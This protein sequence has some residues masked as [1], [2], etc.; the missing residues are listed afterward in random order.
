MITINL[1]S[2]EEKKDI[3][4]ERSNISLVGSF[5]ILGFVLIMLTF[6][7]YT[8]SDVQKGT[9]NAV[10]SETKN[11]EKFLNQEGNAQIE[12]KIKQINNYLSTI[13]AIEEDRTDFAKTLTEIANQTITGIR[14]FDIKLNKTD[15]NFE[16]S[17]NAVARDNLVQFTSNLGKTGYFESIESPPSNLISPTDISFKVTGKLTDKALK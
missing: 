15:K 2:S 1:L 3:S 17:G 4:Y 14:I 11:I 8:I 6:V 13:K 9:L 5:V 7:L 10:A 16:I 12:S